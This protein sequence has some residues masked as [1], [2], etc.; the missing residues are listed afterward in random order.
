MA[1]ECRGIAEQLPASQ[2]KQTEL[3]ANRLKTAALAART[4]KKAYLAEYFS[5]L[6]SQHRSNTSMPK[7]KAKTKIKI[8]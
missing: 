2:Q 6:V 7:K 8:H 5:H 4:K 3:L 1:R